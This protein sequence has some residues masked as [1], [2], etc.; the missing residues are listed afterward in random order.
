MDNIEAFLGIKK[1]IL[2]RALKST[3]TPSK[4]PFLH[5]MYTS[6]VRRSIQT[7][8]ML[9]E[10]GRNVVNREV[11]SKIKRRLNEG[12]LHTKVRDY[13]E[14]STMKCVGYIMHAD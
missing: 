11:R 13:Y 7:S 6:L 5:Q 14:S 3:H 2:K 12:G 10:Y 4:T 8:G 1:K 9:W